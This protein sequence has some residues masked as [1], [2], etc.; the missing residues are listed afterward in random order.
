MRLR[1]TTALIVLSLVS[2][3]GCVAMFTD[4][5]G[6]KA[7]F[8]RTQRNYTKFLR[9]GDVEAAARYVHPEQ[10]EEFL[11]YEGAFEGIRVTDFEVGEV[12]YGEKNAT[13]SI[14]VTYRAYS[15]A[16]MLEKKIKETQKWERLGSS[17]DWVVRPE[18]DGLVG[19]VADLR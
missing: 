8:D 6:R 1:L 4:P 13:A 9:W 19:Q 10:R 15:L 3:S 7:A 11:D 16:S 14:R 18:I 5:M 12:E 17:N 2:S